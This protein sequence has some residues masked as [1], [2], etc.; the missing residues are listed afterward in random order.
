[1]KKKIFTLLALCL[2]CLGVSAANE[3]VF[4]WV[5]AEGTPTTTGG[6]VTAYKDASTE[7][8]SL[9]N[10][11]SCGHYVLRVQGNKGNGSSTN[12]EKGY[13]KIAP[14]SALNGT[15]KI[16]VEGF[17]NKSDNGTATNKST[18]AYFLFYQSGTYLTSV[19]T[20]SD[21]D[22]WPNL[23][24]DNT[25]ATKTVDLDVPALAAG[26][27]EIRIVRANT[28]TNFWIPSISITREIQS[29]NEITCESN[30]LGGKI[31]ADKVMAESGTTITLTA[32][33]CLGWELGSWSVI[34]A[35]NNSVTVTDNT[36]TMPDKA[37]TVSATFAVGEKVTLDFTNMGS[38]ITRSDEIVGN[39]YNKANS[40]LNDIYALSAPDALVGILAVQ[41]TASQDKKG[42][43]LS[44]SGLSNKDAGRCAALLN[45]TAGTT[46]VITA[47]GTVDL[48]GG[49]SGEGTH[50]QTSSGN[51][52]TVTMTSDGYL[53]FEIEK[54]K[55]ITKMEITA[56]DKVTPILSFPQNAVS[57]KVGDNIT[58][59][60]VEIKSLGGE[61]ISAYYDVVYSISAPK[62]ATI[63]ASTGVVTVSANGSATVTAT[64]TPKDADKYM[65]GFATYTISSDVEISYPYTWTFTNWS[66]ST[67]DALT[68]AAEEGYSGTAWRTQEKSGGA[69]GGFYYGSALS[70]ASLVAEG[71]MISETAGLKFTASNTP[72]IAVINDLQ[73][74]SIG[75][76]E[77]AKYLW[78]QAKNNTITI[79][80][81]PSGK[82]VTVVYETHK[83]G[84]AR[85][86][87]CTV[88]SE[89]TPIFG[90]TKAGAMTTV[91]WVVPE[92]S[93]PVDVV[94]TCLEG[95]CH[96]Y[97]IT[98]EEPI[99]NVSIDKGE[100][101][102]YCFPYDVT[103]P[104]GIE[105][106]TASLSGST[107]TVTTQGDA[108]KIKAGEGVIL[109]N[110]SDTETSFAF[111]ATSGAENFSGNGLTGCT[112]QYTTDCANN[113]Y[114]I[115]Y[116]GTPNYKFKAYTGS[117]IPANK[118]FF[119]V[120]GSDAK[121]LDVDWGEAT[122]IDTVQNAESGVQSGMYNLNG[123][124]VND[125][126]KGIVI[127]N[128]KKYIK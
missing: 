98:V 80:S 101:A 117:Y 11:T 113:T 16:T 2:V 122:S 52:Y 41:A 99:G 56:T 75:E 106:S 121:E 4:S 105:V 6:T 48:T 100:F 127:M 13:I 68:E 12:Y 84:T 65:S 30:L 23:A 51:V 33:P 1:M 109:K 29:G 34:D 70:N 42:Y 61:D 126:Y 19:S 91:K 32:T 69:E 83:S 54:G 79:P 24:I 59:Q 97:S 116:K 87:S 38:T 76:Y 73:S 17:Q 77:Y 123:V 57:A 8:A 93:D 64:A 72:A 96:I 114:Y 71:V 37:V 86:F 120:A 60:V 78:I 63:N 45:L 124:R 62:F 119:V 53:G 5:G 43:V 115:L 36:F 111:A 108:T 31:S 7:D 39:A 55:Y 94:L 88:G 66:S 40:K 20:S 58:S 112:E 107:V 118:A 104:E 49:G 9:I 3:T 82:I 14:T 28:G 27:D 35:D 44:S 95:G 81:V 89:Q 74:T 90:A 21:A 128:G 22:Y 47:N 92:S 125:S 10:A 25:I 103:V 102:T 50:I 46:V 15:E 18:G 26:A 85:G 110:V 67:I